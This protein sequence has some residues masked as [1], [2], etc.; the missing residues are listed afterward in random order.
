MFDYGPLPSTA[1]LLILVTGMDGVL[2]AF[3]A[4]SLCGAV[5]GKFLLPETNG[6]TLREIEMSFG[7]HGQGPD[8][9]KQGLDEEAAM[10]P[11]SAA[12][13]KNSRGEAVTAPVDPNDDSILDIVTASSR[14]QDVYT[15]SLGRQ[16]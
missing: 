9:D 1:M 4:L 3:S 16:R 10:P 7:G 11:A 15:I 12:A 2:W 5:F 13:R 8:K 14:G 6:R